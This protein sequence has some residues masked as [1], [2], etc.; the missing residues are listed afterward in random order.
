MMSCRFCL[1]NKVKLSKVSDV[2]LTHIDPSAI[3]GLPGLL[4]TLETGD[5]TIPFDDPDE[6]LPALGR[7]WISFEGPLGMHLI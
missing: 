3:S 4:L 7:R 6:S 5:S 2:L 1:E